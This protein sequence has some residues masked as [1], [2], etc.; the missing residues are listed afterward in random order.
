MDR[1]HS[2][3]LFLSFIETP[4]ERCGVV[5]WFV[6]ST[7]LPL[8]AHQ[9]MCPSQLVG[10]IREHPNSPSFPSG[11]IL[12]SY[13]H[14]VGLVNGEI[15]CVYMT[16]SFAL[17]S[18]HSLQLPRAVPTKAVGWTSHVVRYQHQSSCLSMFINVFHSVSLCGSPPTVH[19][20]YD[21]PA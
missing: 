6:G 1:L 14:L 18:V 15:L 11:R 20:I 2:V 17:L 13:H 9:T 8:P 12:I 10:S 21:A 4:G 7:A 19:G 5:Y 16:L 3:S